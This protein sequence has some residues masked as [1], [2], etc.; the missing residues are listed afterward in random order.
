MNKILR[1]IFAAI[2]AVALFSACQETEIPDPVLLELD[3]SNMKMTV[4]QSQKLYAVLKGSDEKCVWKTADASIALVDQ[5]GLVT[6][7]AAGK[8]VI[9]VE[10]G[11]S[12]K[13]CNVEVVD[14]K[15]DALEWND[16]IQNHTL[17]VPAGENY[18][19][20]AKFYKAGEKVN[21]L[22]FPMYTI[23][24]VLPS[25]TGETVAAIDENGLITTSAPGKAVVTVS[26]AGISK[27]FTLLVKEVTLNAATLNVFVQ[28]TG[29]LSV[30]VLPE[31]LP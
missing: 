13:E 22:A 11:R 10:A 25:R 2:S 27:S 20:Q 21:D 4:G 8:T 3:R 31:M 18:Q 23:S 14:F 26:G 12:S 28:E 1:V 17:I 29:Q 19:L 24:E 7:V 9:S 6:A 5:S 30:S 16:D 15:A